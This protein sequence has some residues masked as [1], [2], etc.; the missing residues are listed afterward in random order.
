MTTFLKQQFSQNLRR[1]R[2]AAGISQEK[3]GVRA[4][5]H[6]NIVGQ[7]ELATRLPDLETLLKLAAGLELQPALLLDGMVWPDTEDSQSA[8]C[9]PR[10]AP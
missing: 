10:E 4:N 6:R 5:V 8:Q 2:K 1:H 7:L 3:L 9:P